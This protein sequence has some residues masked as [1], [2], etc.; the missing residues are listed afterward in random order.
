MHNIATPELPKDVKLA[1]DEFIQEQK[2][3]ESRSK[4]KRDISQ[5]PNAGRPAIQLK[6]PR[7]TIKERP[8]SGYPGTTK[9]ASEKKEPI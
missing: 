8:Q 9:N 6:T 3:E 2:K 7:S 4:A 1:R 5:N